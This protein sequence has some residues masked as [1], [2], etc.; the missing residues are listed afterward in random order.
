MT[1]LA[2]ICTRLHQTALAASLVLGLGGATPALADARAGAAVFK[3]ECAVCHS[4]RRNEILVG[5]SLAGVVGRKAGTAATFPYSTA[6]K[7]F[8]AVWN[9]D[10]LD[11]F[12]AAPR[13]TVPRINM[14]SPGVPDPA[15][16]RDLVAYLATL[17]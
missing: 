13:K 15:Q 7:T 4:A 17:K 3:R 10:L 6:M 16:R 1:I 14:A 2:T 9:A 12:I 11:S 5:P 8:G